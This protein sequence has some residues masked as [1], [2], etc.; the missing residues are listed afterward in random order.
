MRLLIY[1][2]AFIL[3]LMTFNAKITDNTLKLGDGNSSNNKQI[4]MT[5]GIIKWDGSAGKL[6][7]SNDAGSNYN[8]IGSGGGGGAAGINTVLNGDFESGSAT[9]TTEA[10]TSGGF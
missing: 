9:M 8:D 10:F 7:F 5:D 2:L 4:E 1:A 3:A 6:K